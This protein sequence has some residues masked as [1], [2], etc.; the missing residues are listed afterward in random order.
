MAEQQEP[1]DRNVLSDKDKF[2]EKPE[3]EKITHMGDKPGSTPEK[4]RDQAKE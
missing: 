2:K 3:H 4:Q 1:Q